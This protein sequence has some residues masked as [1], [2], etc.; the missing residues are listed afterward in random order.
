MVKNLV[1]DDQNKKTEFSLSVSALWSA[2]GLARCIIL[3]RFLPCLGACLSDGS[4]TFGSRTRL[5]M[6]DLRTYYTCTLYCV[7]VITHGRN[8]GVAAEAGKQ[9]GLAM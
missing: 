6:C 2:S 3:L 1:I 9:L 7:I 8:W 4:G 5:V